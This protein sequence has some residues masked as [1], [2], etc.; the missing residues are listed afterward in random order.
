M[1]GFGPQRPDEGAVRA[2]LLRDRHGE[3]GLAPLAELGTLGDVPQPVE[4]EV[5]A[6]VDGHERA[7]D[8]RTIA[9]QRVFLEAGEADSSGRLGA[10][11]GI[12]ERVLHRR[13][14]LVR[15]HRDDLVEELAADAE[16]LGADLAHGDAVGEEPNL[17]QRHPLAGVD[18]RGHAGGL[19][20]LDADDL[21]L[22][23]QVLDEAGDPR[24]QPAAADGHEDRLDRIGMLAQDL[25]SH[26]AL[27]GDHVGIVVGRHEREPAL[28]L[29]PARLGECLVETVAEQHDLATAPAHGVDLDARR[30]ARHDDRRRDPELGRCQRHALGVVAG[31]G[32]DDAAGPHLG[33]QA[34]DLVVGAT[35][36]EREDRLQVL[37]LE[38]HRHAEPLRQARHRV[39]RALDRDIIDARAHDL[40]RVIVHD[41]G[42]S[43][44]GGDGRGAAPL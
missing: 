44:R 41:S 8:R 32:G 40:L 35:D 15:R 23:A 5:G 36:L 9:A 18:R 16:G 14:D 1:T 34:D 25:H 2:R 30:R 4:I 27:P 20:R 7:R 21:D 10:G 42:W 19:F 29:E 31:R 37:A 13:A 33:R 39:E 26:R 24:G 22:G 12:V 17:R 43:W 11:A 38:E 6:R 3:H 28:D